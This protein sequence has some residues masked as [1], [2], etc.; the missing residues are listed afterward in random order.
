MPDILEPVFDF[1]YM[2]CREGHRKNLE[3]QE[4]IDSALFDLWMG[5]WISVFCG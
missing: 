2:D 3:F 5:Q 4:S 1:H